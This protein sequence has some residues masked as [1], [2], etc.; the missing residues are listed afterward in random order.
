MILLLVVVAFTGAVFWVFLSFYGFRV[1]DELDIEN[2]RKIHQKREQ[3]AKRLNMED[4]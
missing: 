1:P 4:K 2:E 3:F